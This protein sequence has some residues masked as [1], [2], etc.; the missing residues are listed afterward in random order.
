MG[1]YMSEGCQ[2]SVSSPKTLETIKKV[3]G[4]V[5]TWDLSGKSPERNRL[6]YRGGRQILGA[7]TEY[8]KL[9]ITDRD[10]DCW[11]IFKAE[12]DCRSMS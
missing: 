8:R 9:V 6:S 7:N 3:R 1:A 5:R 12:Y 2:K 10:W 4:G 11:R